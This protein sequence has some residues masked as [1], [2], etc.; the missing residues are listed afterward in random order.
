[1]GWI[2]PHWKC[3][4]DRA[5]NFSIHLPNRGKLSL[6]LQTIREDGNTFS[7]IFRFHLPVTEQTLNNTGNYFHL[8]IIQNYNPFSD[9]ETMMH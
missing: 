6:L 3:L 4:K 2:Q 9:L 1:M 7:I 8:Q 5:T